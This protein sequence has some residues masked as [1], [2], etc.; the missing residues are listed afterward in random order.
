MCPFIVSNNWHARG[1]IDSLSFWVVSDIFEEGRLGDTVFHG[2]FGMVNA[3]GLKKPS[4]YGYWFLSQLGDTEL[5]SGGSYAITRHSDGS[6]RAL[7]WNY[8]HYNEQGNDSRVVKKADDLYSLFEQKETETFSLALSGLQD[9]INVKTTRFGRKHGSVY[10]A[11]REMGSPEPPTREQ[12]AE[13]KEAMELAVSEEQIA[14][15]NGCVGLAVSVEAH[16]VV[17]LEIR[18]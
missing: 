7:F 17:L 3:Q 5:A 9:N 1:Y 12:T 2:G 10:D 4:Y 18:N 11:W 14:A 16:G 6:I 8:C 13:L 15:E